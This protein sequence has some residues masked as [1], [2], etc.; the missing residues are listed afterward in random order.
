MAETG[1]HATWHTILE[2]KVTQ[3]QVFCVNISSA[4]GTFLSNQSY[5]TGRA[6][7]LGCKEEPGTFQSA[8]WVITGLI[9]TIWSQC[10][11]PSG[12]KNPILYCGCKSWNCIQSCTLISLSEAEWK[13]TDNGTPC[14]WK[15]PD[16]Y[17]QIFILT[18]YCFS[19]TPVCLSW[20][21]MLT[22]RS[23]LRAVWITAILARLPNTTCLEKLIR[24]NWDMPN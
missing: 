18:I 1:I 3:T 8:V 11:C 16:F 4:A 6:K 15:F 13:C 7:K 24:T 20:G 17:K 9:L 21:T 23:L 22:C 12:Y 10:L 19:Q 14:L 2:T 5:Q